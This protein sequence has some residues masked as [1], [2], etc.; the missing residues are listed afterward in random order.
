M[1]ISKKMQ[2]DLRSRAKILLSKPILEQP[3]P[4][5]PVQRTKAIIV[6]P[7]SSSIA[8]SAMGGM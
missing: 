5:D 6:R 2:L 4:V 1:L 8:Q 3:V 7:D